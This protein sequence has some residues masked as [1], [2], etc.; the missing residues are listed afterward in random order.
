MEEGTVRASLR[1]EVQVT[2]LLVALAYGLMRVT[3]WLFCKVDKGLVWLWRKA[4][5]WA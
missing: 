1:Q 5:S 2:N 4:T 3:C